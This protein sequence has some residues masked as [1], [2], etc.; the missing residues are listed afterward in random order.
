[1]RGLVLGSLGAALALYALFGLLLFVKQRDFLYPRH[2]ISS[3]VRPPPPPFEAVAIAT[4]DG[5]RLRAWHAAAREGFATI[6]LLH[7][8]GDTLEGLAPRLSALAD[9]GHGVL[10]LA[11][12]GY[13]GSSGTPSEDGLTL[14]T[15]AALDWL[16]AQGVP[17]HRIVL[18]GRSL[19]SGL[20]V[21]AAARR[22]VGAVVLEAAYTSIRELA[23]S[24]FPIYPARLI[25]RDPYLSADRIGEVR[26]PLM[27]IH[28]RDDALI[29]H[30]MSAQLRDLAGSDKK[31]LVVV[32]HAGHNDLDAFGLVDAIDAF[33]G[34][35]HPR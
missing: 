24:A 16:A 27:L 23:Q 21:K 11:F 1:M 25:L 29:P 8:N 19:G 9:R 3:A 2:L 31:T 35:I 13:P 12:R 28:G 32:D 15:F 33:L 14:D 20:A 26:A 10:G 6:L 30:R 18:L 34:E 17:D 5:E 4:P 7:G 22:A